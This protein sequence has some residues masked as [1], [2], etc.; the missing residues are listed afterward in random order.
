LEFCGSPALRGRSY[1]Y[2]HLTY[3][4]R[5]MRAERVREKAASRGVE[6]GITPLEMPPLEDANSVQM[7]L[8]QVIDAIL[9]DRIDNKRAGLVLYALQTGS[10]NLARTDL[11]Q[12]SGATVAGEYE[13]FEDDFDLEGGAEQLRADQEQEQGEDRAARNST[14]ARIEEIAEVCAKADAA[15]AEAAKSRKPDESDPNSMRASYPCGH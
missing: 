2:F 10:S 1:Y 4:G 13:D 3:I 5:R 14:I 9:H 6:A 15:E 7:A 8:M 11:E 12:M